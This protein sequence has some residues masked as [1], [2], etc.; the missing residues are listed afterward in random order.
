MP[1]SMLW[2]DLETFGTHPR[3][4]RI[5]QFAAV[6]TTDKFE[7]IEPPV[8]IVCRLSPDYV[9]NPDACLKTGITPEAVNEK[10]MTERDFALRVHTEM[11]RPAT[12]TAGFNNL[13]FDD[14]FV[15][16]L[17]YRNFYDPYSR[18]YESENSRWDIIDLLRMCRDLRPEGIEWATSEDGK[19]VFRLEDL[20]RANSIP[21]ESAH[22]ALSDVRATLAL[23]KLVHEKQRKLFKYYFSLRKKEEVRRKLNLQRML[24]VVHTSGMFTSPRGCTTL[25]V[26]LSVD[27][28]QTN[29]V[30]AYDL[31]RDPRDWLDAP[32]EEVRRRVFTRRE[33]LGEN[34]RI[35][36]KGIHL[37]RCPAV[38]PLSTLEEDRA[39]ELGI[40]IK[41]CLAHAEILRGRSD[42]IQ[43]V[44]S[45]YSDRPRPPESDV[46]LKIYSGDFFPAEDRVEFDQIR[47]S[48]P[49]DL[50]DRPPRLHD[51]RGQEM[52]WRYLARNFPEALS[53]DD[54]RRWKSFCASRLLTPEPP[55]AMDIGTYMRDVRNRLSRVDTPARDKV[56]L[57][58]L[59]EYGEYLE[60]TILS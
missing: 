19:P 16:S 26:P 49:E 25:V 20:A 28:R 17:F 60:K 31:R 41:T 1:F 24:P 22:D 7:E 59:L 32:V 29:M 33:E 42:I 23:A 48:S 37:N 6:R 35:P 36:F 54:R 51:S 40:D 52:L 57:K 44:R 3:W 38:A 27:P 53:E 10:G 14:E 9:P 43:K 47:T 34:E 39:R 50:R 12:C 45:V 21:H 30:I 55:G 15:R 56:V 46:D 13:R 11:S 58:R 8:N 4:D 18:E 5:A 2:Y